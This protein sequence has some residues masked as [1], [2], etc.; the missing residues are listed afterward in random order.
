MP[1]TA[2]F[3]AYYPSG[4]GKAMAHCPMSAHQNGDSHPSLS[5]DLVSNRAQCLKPGCP[6]HGQHGN[7]VLDAYQILHGLTF[8]Q[9]IA[10]MCEELGI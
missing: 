8:N 10:A 3:P 5:L 9:A 2:I 4:D 1:I 7:D 6:L